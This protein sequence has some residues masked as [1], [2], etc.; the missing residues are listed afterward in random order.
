MS[1]NQI[2]DVKLPILK[3]INKYTYIVYKKIVVGAATSV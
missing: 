2:H 1:R 3:N